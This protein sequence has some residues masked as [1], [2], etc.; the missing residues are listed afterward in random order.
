[1]FCE[2]N[3][4]YINTYIHI[5]IYIYTSEKEIRQQDELKCPQYFVLGFI[6]REGGVVEVG[7][8]VCVGGGGGVK[9]H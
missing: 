9:S 2:L 1:M 4:I 5:N 8:C 3:F 7:V 6:W